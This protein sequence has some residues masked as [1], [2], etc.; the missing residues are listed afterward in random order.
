MMLGYIE[1]FTC[2]TVWE[3]NFKNWRKVHGGYKKISNSR[4]GRLPGRHRGNTTDTHAAGLLLKTSGVATPSKLR[5]L[6]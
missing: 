6:I 2:Y 3:Q 5:L 1:I 4:A